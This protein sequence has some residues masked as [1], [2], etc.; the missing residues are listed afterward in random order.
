MI[1]ALGSTIIVRPVYDEKPSP[2][3][4]LPKSCP[5]YKLYH[6][7]IHGEVLAVGPKYPYDLKVG[8]KILWRRHEGKPIRVENEL[9]FVLSEK[10]V[11][12]KLE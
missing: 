8:D 9:L 10:W 4:L 1:Q 3:I 5:R 6:G 7:A 11:E 12:G 2:Q